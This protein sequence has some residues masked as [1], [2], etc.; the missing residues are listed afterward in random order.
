MSSNP[1]SS[2]G[3]DALLLASDADRDLAIELLSEAYSVGRLTADELAQRTERALTAR[4]H[5]DLDQVLHGLGGL[6]RRVRRRPVRTTVF[7]VAAVLGS[8][9][10]LLGILLLTAGVDGGDRFA[11]VVF[12]GVVVPLLWSVRRR[13]RSS[14]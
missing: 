7:W 4:T 5:G 13:S 9:F 11:G 14:T 10:L 3:P 8:P 2:A 12:L 1:P 6:R